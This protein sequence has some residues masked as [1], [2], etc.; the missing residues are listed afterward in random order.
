[1]VHA[2]NEMILN[3]KTTRYYIPE[4]DQNDQEEKNNDIQII[5]NRSR[6]EVIFGG[7]S[8]VHSPFN[9]GVIIT[10]LML[11]GYSPIDRGSFR[12]RIC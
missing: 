7:H 11:C 8:E 6:Y 5:S 9:T 10:V 2:I 4:L 12:P 1:M 3:I